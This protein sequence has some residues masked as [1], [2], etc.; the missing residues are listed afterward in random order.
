MKQVEDFILEKSLGFSSFGE[1]YLATK[2][3]SPEKYAVKCYDREETDKSGIKHYL[4]NEMIFLEKI[5]HPNIIK[6]HEIKKTKKH[7]YFFYEYCN[8]G[9]LSDALENYKIKYG[10]PFP[11]EII[12]YFMKQIIDAFYYLHE[13]KIIHRCIN[14]DNIL[15]N[16]ENEEDLKNLNLIKAKIKII[17][18]IYVCRAEKD[19]LQKSLQYIFLG[20][21]SS[22]DPLIIKNF[23]R[24]NNKKI[25]QF[26]YSTRADIWSI[27]AICYE[28]LIGKSL[29]HIEDVSKFFEKGNYTI[30][31]SLSYEIVAFINGMLQY[32]AF[33]RLTASQLSRHDFL[34]KNVNQFKIINLEEKLIDKQEINDDNNITIW[35]IYSKKDENLLISIL[36][37]DYV[38]A[39]DENEELEF[40]KANESSLKLSLKEIP[41]NPTD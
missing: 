28:M 31:H 9:K 32:N 39:I 37:G 20:G 29:F 6:L 1:A 7:Y 23:N 15:L 41:A 25:K 2:N 38:V 3:G 34:N 40:C 16:Y 22:T 26:G 10:K 5:N 33:K 12:Q 36:A 8:G 13:K 35:S 27:G 14:L 18:F 24:P 4:G 11:E 17:D 30:P 21:S 19:I